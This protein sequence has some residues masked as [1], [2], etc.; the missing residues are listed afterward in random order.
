MKIAFPTN[1]QNLKGEINLH[2][3]RAKYYLVYD[4][5]NQSFE[6]LENPEMA[7]KDELPPDFLK[8]RGVDVVVA[9]A[10][11]ARAFEKFNN[12]GI[13]VYKAK[14]KSIDENITYFEKKQLKF[15]DQKDIF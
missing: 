4:T 9:L 15:L 6:V 7:G 2:F 11:G 10:M 12:L 1:N 3:G 5:E 14:G 13:K 8:K